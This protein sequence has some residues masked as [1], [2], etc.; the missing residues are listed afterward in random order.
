MNF[1]ENLLSNLAYV[2]T[3][4]VVSPKLYLLLGI[5]LQMLGSETNFD[6]AAFMEMHKQMIAAIIRAIRDALIQKLVEKLYKLVGYLAEEIGQKM[7]IE[8]ILYYKDLLKKCIECFK[9]W[10]KDRYMDFD[11]NNIDYADILQDDTEDAETNK[12]C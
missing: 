5:N 4:A 10:G 12:N 3:S 11:V 2:I 8:Q 1:I 6:L 9:L 7:S